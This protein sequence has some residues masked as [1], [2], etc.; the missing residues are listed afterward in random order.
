MRPSS[1]CLFSV[2]LYPLHISTGIISWGIDLLGNPTGSVL[3]S[4]GNGYYFYLCEGIDLRDPQ[5]GC[6]IGPVTIFLLYR[7]NFDIRLPLSPVDT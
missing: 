5:N 4:E 3:K 7:Y 1:T 6:Q 2:K